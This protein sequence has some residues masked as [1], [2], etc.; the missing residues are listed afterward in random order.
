MEE[1]VLNN[2]IFGFNS[3]VH[4][5]NAGTAIRIKFAPT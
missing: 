2:D 5:Q 3:K 4:Q 1:L